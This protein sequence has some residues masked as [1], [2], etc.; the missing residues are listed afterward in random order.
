MFVVGSGMDVTAVTSHLQ[1][2][3]GMPVSAPDP[4]RVG[5]G[6][7]A[8]AQPPAGA[9]ATRAR[10]PSVPRQRLHGPAAVAV[11]SRVLARAGHAWTA[12][13]G[14]HWWAPACPTVPTWTQTA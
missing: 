14:A 8:A 4:A 9:A 10:T 13:N 5:V 3:A 11:D 1:N 2:V 6:P 12:Q 7:L